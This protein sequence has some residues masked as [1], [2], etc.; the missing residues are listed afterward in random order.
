MLNGHSCG[1]RESKKPD[2]NWALKR[3]KTGVMQTQNTEIYIYGSD[4]WARE[5][6]T[7]NNI[8]NLTAFIYV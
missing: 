2:V 8:Q 4:S 5:R 7:N 3:A 1:E 6:I